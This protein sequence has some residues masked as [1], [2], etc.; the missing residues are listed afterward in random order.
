MPTS[1]NL[2][3]QLL[4]VGLASCCGLAAAADEPQAAPKEI[5]LWPD[6]APGAVG[7]EAA[8]KPAVLVQLPPKEKANGTAVV[9]CPGGG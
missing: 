2:W 1:R 7:S 9:V 8:D 4:L 3:Q 6:G 5:L